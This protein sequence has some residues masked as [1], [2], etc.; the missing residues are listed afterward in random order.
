MEKG[1][2]PS[3]ARRTS[4]RKRK[5]L[6]LRR[7]SS[8]TT[9]SHIGTHEQLLGGQAGGNAVIGETWFKN[10]SA[11]TTTLGKRG[12]MK[13]QVDVPADQ[14]LTQYIQWYIQV[15]STCTRA[16]LKDR[17]TAS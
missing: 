17:L 15:S 1:F 14:P 5:T 7:R 3:R 11:L 2:N 6:S 9:Y 16:G 12:Q 10:R 8:M 13:S 4:G